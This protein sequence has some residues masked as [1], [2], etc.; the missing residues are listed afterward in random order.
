ME[1]LIVANW[2][3][4]KTD[5]E[6]EIFLK[7]FLDYE[8]K[9]NVKVC[10]CPPS[11]SLNFVNMYIH[12]NDYSGQVVLGGQNV[13]ENCTGAYTGEVSI[14][15]LKQ[16]NVKYVIVGHSERKKYFFENDDIINKKISVIQLNDITPILCVGETHEEY[17]NKLTRKILANQ[18]IGALKCATD[19]VVIAYEPIWAVGT[20]LLP[21]LADIDSTLHYIKQCVKQNFN[22][23][24]QVL[25]GGSLNSKNAGEIL[26]LEHID[27]ALV[28]GASLDSEEFYKI[29]QS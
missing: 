19:N 27:G 16:F 29:I 21:S 26:T 6:A 1:K 14:Y 11:T 24:V 8:F 9:T 5:S 28:G 3:M 23:N 17:K 12:E 25:Y 15:M 10:I 22:F 18:L 20:G 4:N 7:R 2:K 13:N